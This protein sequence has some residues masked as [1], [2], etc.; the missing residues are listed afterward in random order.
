MALKV[1]TVGAISGLGFEECVNQFNVRV[2]RLK[3]LGYEVYSPMLGKDHLRNETSLRSEGYS[4]SPVSNDHS[5]TKADFWKVDI[6]DILFVDLTNAVDRVSI[7]S[8]AEMSRGYAKGKLVVTV[9]QKEN[10]HR[11]AFVNEMSSIIFE[12][13]EQAFEYF[14]L[15][16][17]NNR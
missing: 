2:D 1:Y 14:K 15:Y 5:I 11:H 16:A 10:I 6:S 12:D 8:V 7:G 3:A 4:D 9:M 13:L 17:P